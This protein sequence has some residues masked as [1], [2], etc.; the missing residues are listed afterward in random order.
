MH[1]SGHPKNFYLLTTIHSNL[2]N[3]GGGGGYTLQSLHRCMAL[4]CTA[5]VFYEVNS[6]TLWWER[7]PL[8]SLL[9]DTVARTSDFKHAT[10]CVR[11]GLESICI[12]SRVTFIPLPQVPKVVYDI[13]PP[14][15]IQDPICC[16]NFFYEY[17][18][19][20]IGKTCI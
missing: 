16:V 3:R 11:M 5:L 12:L 9:V 2:Y 18:V 4:R 20:L 19:M 6:R 15:K 7:L 14:P 13:A 17:K 10:S 8:H 1:G